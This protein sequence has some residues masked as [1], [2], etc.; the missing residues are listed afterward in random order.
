MRQ[1]PQ[2]TAVVTSRATVARDDAPVL[3]PPV[4]LRPVIQL[5]DDKIDAGRAFVLD[6]PS[7]TPVIVTA[8]S[9]FGPPGGLRQAINPQML[10]ALVGDAVFFDVL[11]GAMRARG[12]L[13]RPPSGARATVTSADGLPDASRDLVALAL[14]P[15]HSMK[16]LQLASE[17]VVES[18]TLWLP[19]PPE[20]GLSTEES[21][22]AGNV[23]A[24][25]DQGFSVRFD[26]GTP[27]EDCTGAPLFD[28]DGRVTAMLVGRGDGK[29]VLAI[30]M[31]ASS[32]A[33]R[34]E[35]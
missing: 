27:V 21:L 15:G 3:E 19:M 34:L 17:P 25:W 28:S 4:L 30:A 8:A 6:T 9:L 14:L 20:R 29:G 13:L 10:P 22:L 32:I 1:A 11:D 31:P 23:V 24:T 12:Q 7:G 2:D 5:G 18:Q 26:A 16:P 33:A 35:P